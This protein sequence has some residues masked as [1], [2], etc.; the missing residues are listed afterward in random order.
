[1]SEG[2]SPKPLT[3]GTYAPPGP[4]DLRSPCP[5]INTLA[6]HGYIPRDGRNVTAKQLQS[7]TQSVGGASYVL[8]SMLS[9]PIY[10]EHHAPLATKDES[11]P[12]QPKASFITKVINAFKSGAF[13]WGVIASNVGMRRPGQMDEHGVPVL[14]LD[15]L[16]LPGIVEHDVSL[17]RLDHA[18][19]DNL[20]KQKELVSQLL[21]SS[22][23]GGKTISLA[24]LADLRKRR[25]A[26]Q[27]E[28]NKEIVY[29]AAQHR[30]A[31]GESALLLGVFGDNGESVR[32]DVARAVFEDE[33]LPVEEGWVKGS[34]GFRSVGAILK[35][36]QEAVGTF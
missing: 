34:P 19:G 10:L 14:D 27:R 28:N 20:S 29:G 30:L 13:P 3:K 23:D 6:N 36:I 4:N 25:I 22:S 26:K 2:P 12:P 15:Q 35:R 7:A 9:H 32:V 31:C 16:A 24:D 21:D 18:Q 5:F 11:S 33:R 1:M 17:T 8:S